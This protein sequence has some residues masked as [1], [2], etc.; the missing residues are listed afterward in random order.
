[1]TTPT[2]P[3]PLDLDEMRRLHEQATAGEWTIKHST[4]IFGHR[5]DCG[6]VGGIAN[7]GGH[8]SNVVDCNPENQANAAFI[9]FAHNHWPA[10]L[11][12]IEERDRLR[13][14]NE[15]LERLLVCYRLGRHPSDK[16]LDS[17]ERLR[18]RVAEL[19]GRNG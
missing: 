19:E 13:E 1:M 16:L 15:C 14:L 12:A 8:A 18:A 3:A 11:A 4:N 9:V 7:T 2:N 5:S 6:Y 17:I 10:I